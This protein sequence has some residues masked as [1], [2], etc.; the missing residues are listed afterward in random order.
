ME[1]FSHHPSH[2]WPDFEWSHSSPWWGNTTQVLLEHFT[3]G[4]PNKTGNEADLGK[5]GTVLAHRWSSHWPFGASSWQ[6]HSSEVAGFECFFPKWMS[7]APIPAQWWLFQ[8]LTKKKLKRNF[9]RMFIQLHL[10]SRW[11]TWGCHHIDCFLFCPL[12]F[13][14]FP[15]NFGIGWTRT[16]C[17]VTSFCK[18]RD[19]C[20]S[21]N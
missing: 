21:P 20:L 3:D 8:G 2:Q 9:T 16:A 10:L 19:H 1:S 12:L 5:Q 13:I 11:I 4:I 18:K 6:I 17:I 15:N 14:P 7:V